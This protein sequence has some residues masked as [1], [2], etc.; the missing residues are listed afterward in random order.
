MSVKE[1]FCM[2]QFVRRTYVLFIFFVLSSQVL[3]ASPIKEIDLASDT[4][5]TVSVDGGPRRPIKVTG[6]GWNSDQQDPPIGTGDV[7]DHVTYER[8]ITIPADAAGATERTHPVFDTG[9]CQRQQSDVSRRP[10][11]I[12]CR[13]NITQL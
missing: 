8:I 12:E 11:P 4:A 2:N 7:K 6:G 1:N 3:S 10:N 13:E 5:W 9:V